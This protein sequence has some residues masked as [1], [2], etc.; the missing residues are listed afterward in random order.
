LSKTSKK[1]RL[2]VHE[3]KTQIGILFLFF[4]MLQKYYTFNVFSSAS[5]KHLV[6]VSEEKGVLNDP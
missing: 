5:S 2:N 3:T 4:E 1:G 6:S